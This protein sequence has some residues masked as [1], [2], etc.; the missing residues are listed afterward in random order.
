MKNIISL[1]AIIFFLAS[2]ICFPQTDS[3]KISW[4]RNSE[5]DVLYYI[6]YRAVAQDTNLTIFDYDSAMMVNQ[7]PAG[8]L[9]VDTTDKDNSVILP[10]NYISYLVVA[11]DS[12]G[13]RS[14]YSDPDAAGIPKIS[15]TITHIDPARTTQVLLNSFLY[16]PDHE[17]SDLQDSIWNSVNI[18]VNRNDN[19]LSL[20]P[21]SNAT[22]NSA[23]FILRFT[24]PEGFWDIDTIELNIETNEPPEI[25]NFISDQTILEGDD[26]SSIN[27]DN[28]V[29][30]PD[31]SDEDITWTYSGNDSLTVTISPNRIAAIDVPYSDWNGAD[32]IVFIATDPGGLSASDTAIFKVIGV[33][34]PPQMSQISDTTISHGSVYSYQVRAS[35]PDQRYGDIL[36]YTLLNSPIFI[37]IDNTGMI[38]GMIPRDTSGVFPVTVEVRDTSDAFDTQQ[39]NLT[40]VSEETPLVSSIPDQTVTQGFDF[41]PVDLNE[42]VIDPDNPDNEITWTC[43]GNINLDISINPMRVASISIPNAQWTGSETIIFTATDPLGLHSSDAATFTVIKK[44]ALDTLMMEWSP[45]QQSA[46][47][48]VVSVVETKVIFDFWLEPS[49]IHTFRTPNLANEHI[50]ELTNL[51]ADTTYSYTLFLEDS[52]GFVSLISESSFETGPA[53]VKAFLGEPFA[54]PNPYRPSKG[55]DRVYFDN[56]PPEA[57]KIMIFDVAGDEVFTHNFRNP[58]T[59]RWEWLVENRDGKQLASGL[60]IYVILGNGGKKIK[61]G[62]IAVIR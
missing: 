44:P 22:N 2:Q 33:N 29:N 20:T 6:L 48:R 34:D 59:R 60:Y 47:F 23:Y 16:D 12:A 43:S 26:F 45:D 51:V 15:W 52:L 21:D 61:S 49:L 58:P 31:N 32:T 4:D 46:Q 35:D 37:N 42:Y 10:G 38:S 36:T 1:S 56:I 27:L 11:V 25:A 18:Q 28:V 7:S 55:H 3:L 17:N 62:K 9:R 54:F 57:E 39:Y 8:V 53:S 41:T 40:V 50:F 13:M 24:D 30:D 5:D 19:V 14:Y